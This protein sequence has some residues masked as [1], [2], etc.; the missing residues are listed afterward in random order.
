MKTK[1]EN[2]VLVQT[3]V[4]A[5]PEL[6]WKLWTNPE[7]IEKWN[8]ASDDWHTAKAENDLRKGGEF[9]FRMEARDGSEGFDFIGV[10][11]DVI[12]DEKIEYTLG[13]GRKVHISFSRSNGKT[14]IIESFEPE[15][16]NPVK[17]Q[18]DGW[19]SILNNFKRYAEIRSALSKPHR[20]THQITP[21]LW[22]NK[23]A[24]EAAAFY[25][26][27]FKNSRITGKTNYTKEGYD[28][29][30]MEEGSVMTIDFQIDGQPFT[31]LNGGPVFKF[32]EAVSLQIICDTQE[33]IDYYW[34]RLAADGGS[35]GQCGWL[36]DKFG[37]S[38]QVVPSVLS[39]LISN[40]ERAE[41]VMKAMMPMKKLDIEALRKA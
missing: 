16:Q 36:K 32:N 24:E 5:P 29:H 31:F 9:R 23:N 34:E 6:V 41:R 28:I 12:P 35:E 38:W 26:S 21:C 4:D 13:D 17:T 18:Q 40:P 39:K 11:D 20:I 2:L 37:V 30:G 14:K 15:D 19:Q 1:E 25:L 22:F 3:K 8:N 7:D 10:Y 27:I 33:E